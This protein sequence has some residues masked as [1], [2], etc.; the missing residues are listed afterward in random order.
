MVSLS[1]KTTQNVKVNYTTENGTAKTKGTRNYPPDYIAK[2]STLTIP[3]GTLSTTFTVTLLND[4]VPEGKEQFTVQLSQPVNAVIGKG[5]GTI[6][7]LEGSAPISS[8]AQSSRSEGNVRGEAGCKGLA[9]SERSSVYPAHK[10][11]LQ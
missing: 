10:K 4:N 9:Q 7:I 1:K 8:T 11:H 3:A 2:S 5:A 6:V